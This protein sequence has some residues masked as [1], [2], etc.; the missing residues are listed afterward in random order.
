MIVPKGK[1][2]IIGGAVDMGSNLSMQEDIIKPN[3][4]KFFE[5]IGRAH[6]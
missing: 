1:L 3:Y 5:Q 6:V 2:I 4:L